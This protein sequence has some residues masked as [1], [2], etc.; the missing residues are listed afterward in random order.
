MIAPTFVRGGQAVGHAENGVTAQARGALR[1][2]AHPLR[3]EQGEA[4]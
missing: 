2:R 4:R 3:P 1:V